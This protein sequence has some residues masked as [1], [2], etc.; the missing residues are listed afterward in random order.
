MATKI[1]KTTRIRITLDKVIYCSSMIATHI[2]DMKITARLE[3]NIFVPLKG[4]ADL[5]RSELTDLARKHPEHFTNSA[6]TLL[7]T[8]PDSGEGRHFIYGVY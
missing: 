6:H 7:G 4:Q 5:L 2:K 3:H 8:T 1:N